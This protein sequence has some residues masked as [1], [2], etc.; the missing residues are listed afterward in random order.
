MRKNIHVRRLFCTLKS[1]GCQSYHSSSENVLQQLKTVIDVSKW[2]NKI[3]S[4]FETYGAIMKNQNITGY[5]LL[6][7]ITREK[8]E[9]YGIKHEKDLNKI[10]LA[11]MK[12]RQEHGINASAD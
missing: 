6:H 11:I 9:Y 4:S 12:L 5:I 2:I 1:H 8:L 10:W 7:E 3:D